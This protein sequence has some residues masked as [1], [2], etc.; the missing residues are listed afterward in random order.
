MILAEHITGDNARR[1]V[2]LLSLGLS[3][4]AIT[5]SIA[6]LSA[7]WPATR[8]AAV[9]QNR[10][11]VDWLMIGVFV[12]FLGG[13]F[14]SAY[15]QIPWTMNYFC[16]PCATDWIQ[17]GVLPNIMFRNG[18]DILSAG[19]HLRAATIDGD[20]AAG[21]GTRWTALALAAFVLYSGAVFT[22]KACV[23]P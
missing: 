10:T 13:T 18:C 15:W 16:S 6:V 7:W 9:R 22:L 12:G 21:R 2:E 23:H 8:R 4:T 20:A 11:S 5:L 17:W 19:C 14:D 1:F 3:A